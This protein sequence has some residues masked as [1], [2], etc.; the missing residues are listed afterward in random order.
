MFRQIALIACFALSACA[1]VVPPPPPGADPGRMGIQP[2]P[3][4][5][6]ASR[7]AH[8]IGRPMSEAPA[9]GSR[10]NYRLAA[11]DDPLTM[12]FSPQR[13]NIFYDRSTGRIVGIRCF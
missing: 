12:D 8:L 1:T 5:C 6:G 9:N 13:L 3:D 7:Y 2:P 10:P 11:T 4:T